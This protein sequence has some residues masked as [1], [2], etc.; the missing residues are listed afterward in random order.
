MKRLGMDARNVF[1]HPT[2]GNPS[3]NIN[4]GTFGQINSKSGNR[5]IQAQIRL[6]F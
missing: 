5:T 2:P 6:D 3:L 4:T 1:N